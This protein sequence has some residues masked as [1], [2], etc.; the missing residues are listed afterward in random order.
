SASTNVN[1]E[2][3]GRVQLNT[4][5][6][7]SGAQ[8]YSDFTAISTNLS[9][10]QSYTVT[11]TPTWTGTVYPEGYAV[12]I[13]YNH[14][15]DFDD[16]GELVWSQAASTSTPNS[17]N[18]TVPTGTSQTATRMRVSMKYNGIPTSCET[19][20]YGEVEDYTVNLIAGGGGDTQPPTN[21]TNLTAS[22]IT[23][24]TVDLSWTAS[25]DNVGVTG[26]EVFESGVSIGTVGSNS[27]NV[28]G[29][30]ANTSYAFT[31]RAFD[32]AGNNSGFSNTANV[33]TTGGGGNGVIAAYYF[34]TGFDGWSD[35]G[36]DC[37]RV[38]STTA[39]YEGSYS[40]RLRD[41]SSSS[42]SVSP[43][44]NLTGN[45]QVSIEFHTYASSMETGEDFF[46]EFY[47]GSSYQVIGQYISGTHFS[48]NTFF[49]DTILLNA[50]TYNFNA[51]NRFRIRCDAS[52][53]SD[54]IYFDQVIVSGDNVSAAPAVIP[55]DI[56]G[57]SQSFAHQA[58]DNIR[59]Y[60]NPTTS[61]LTI[62]ILDV[63]VDEIMVFSTSG[64]LVK[65]INPAVDDLTF[66]VSRLANG[67]YYVQFVSDGLA[68]TKRFI[69]E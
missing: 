3:I 22:N 51:N 50:A 8:F 36:S 43:V 41:N 7:A 19:F 53:N 37:A 4:I 55:N 65:K 6:N 34:E 57:P 29:L 45:T 54:F 35:G 31:V 47:N 48:N 39:S 62:E 40:I 49:T 58:N 28:T 9:E 60:P 11:V 2:Y 46:V 69:K 68:V 33:T 42:N 1:D 26:Y 25:T 14:D 67:V 21:P 5:D 12:W 38:L 20:T 61:Q 56:S 18:F 52:N 24:T 13:D 32:A 10:G 30:T 59:L 23:D 64:Q 63:D 17:G 16:A 66:D 27:A 15:F 44:L